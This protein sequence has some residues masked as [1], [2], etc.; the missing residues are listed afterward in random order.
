MRLTEHF[1]LEEF[2]HSEIAARRGLDNTPD[3]E[4][5]ERLKATA[6]GMEDVRGLLSVPV[7]VLSGYRSVKVNSAVGGSQS[8]QHMKGEACD[9]IAPSFGTPQEICRAI[10]DSTIEFD[11]LIYE[12]TWAHISFS[13]TPRHSV[14]TAH[15]GNG[16]TTYSQGIA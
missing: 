16:K 4:T 8:S 14:L 9:F 12:G 1:A 7:T 10:L 2:T 13:E 6:S 15:F 11:Q 5:I 3:A